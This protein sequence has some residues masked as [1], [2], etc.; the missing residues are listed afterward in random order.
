MTNFY[1]LSDFRSSFHQGPSYGLREELYTMASRIEDYALIGDCHTAAL[2]AR[3]GSIDWL[4]LPR[5]DSGACF[6]ALLGTPEHG[7][8][9][10]AP[11]GEV[12]AVR[13]RYRDGHPDPRNRLR[14]GRR[15]GRASSIACPPRDPGAGPGA[16]RRG[17]ARPRAHAAWSWSSASTTARL[18][19]GS[20]RIEGGIWAIAGP[21]T[22]ALAHR[23][24]AARRGPGHRGRLHRGRGP[25]GRRS[26]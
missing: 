24:P 14:D 23:R 6:A 10:L 21:D 16:R 5:F 18:Y 3:D 13:R 1:T 9:L 25:A 11:R 4:C 22:L 7:R 15:G 12:R 26:S 8:W 17:Q 20:K 19:P 2:V